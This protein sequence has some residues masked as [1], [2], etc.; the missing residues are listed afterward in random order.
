MVMLPRL[1]NCT[2]HGMQGV[3]LACRHIIAAART[4]KMSVGFFWS[5]DQDQARPDAWCDACEADLVKS[6]W[7]EAWH[8]AAGFEMVCALCWDAAKVKAEAAET[9]NELNDE[10][11]QEE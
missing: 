11:D 1:V 8:Q 9:T 5:D 7:S 3:G 6:D 10:T 4:E 2:Q